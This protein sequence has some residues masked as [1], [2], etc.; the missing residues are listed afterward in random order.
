MV[1]GISNDG[2][3]MHFWKSISVCPF[4]LLV[5]FYWFIY[6]FFLQFER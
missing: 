1:K 2:L 3:E 4:V 5:C 6:C